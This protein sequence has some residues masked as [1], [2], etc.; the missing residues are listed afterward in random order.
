MRAS[1]PKWTIYHTNMKMD[2]PLVGADGVVNNSFSK[3]VLSHMEKR[4]ESLLGL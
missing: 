3:K 1:G 2:E 4:Q